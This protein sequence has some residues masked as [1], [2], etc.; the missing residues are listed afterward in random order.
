MKTVKILSSL[1]IVSWMM[2]SSSLAANQTINVFTWE[3]YVEP[4]EIKAINKIL[5]NKGYDYTVQVISPW[6]EGPEQMFTVLRS[7]KADVSFLTL[8]YINMESGKIAKLLQPINVNSPRIPNYKNLIPAMKDIPFGKDKGKHLYVSWGGGAYG[9]WANM[10][11]LTDADLP[12]SVKGLWDPK[13]RGKLSLTKGQ[14][15]PN[16]SLVMMALDKPPF[17]LNDAGRA[18]LVDASSPNGEIQKKTNA[19][20]ANVSEF[21]GAGPDFNNKS[22]LLVSSYGIAA[23]AANRAGGNWKLVPFKEGNTVWLDTINIH[24]GV[25]GKKLEAV[26]IFINYWLSPVVQDRVVNGLGMVAASTEVKNPLLEA[27]PN[28]FKEG[29]FWPPWKKQ[30]ENVMLK[31]S[32]SAMKNK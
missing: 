12:T 28:F 10:D 11:V 18:A 30:A 14:I 25:S 21:W 5:K 8:N 19:L 16:I 23:S 15:Q 1:I 17:Y 13:W 6:A 4:H 27:D 26:E 3:G 9:I 7:G 31:I 24:K 20:Y 2:V 22:L 32:N 29:F